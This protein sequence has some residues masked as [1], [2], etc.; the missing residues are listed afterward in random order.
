V[1]T[2]IGAD[3]SVSRDSTPR[4]SPAAATYPDRTLAAVTPPSHLN[5]EQNDGSD[6]G[7]VNRCYGISVGRYLAFGDQQHD[8]G[9]PPVTVFVVLL[10]ETLFERVALLIVQYIMFSDE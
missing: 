6:T 1:G 10:I 3:R 9:T 5:I 7:K 4:V 8:N 2:C